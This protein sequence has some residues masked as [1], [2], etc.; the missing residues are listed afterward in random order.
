MHSPLK[1]SNNVSNKAL[2]LH[3]KYRTLNGLLG[4]GQKD[5]TTEVITELITHLRRK[6]VSPQHKQKRSTDPCV[7][8]LLVQLNKRPPT[9]PGGVI[10]SSLHVPSGH[11]PGDH[12]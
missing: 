1:D 6:E 3:V 7:D 8:E 12:Q 10:L 4:N 9:K 11:P 2:V 5:K